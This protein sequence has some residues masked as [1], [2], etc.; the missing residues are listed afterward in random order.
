MPTLAK[1][2]DCLKWPRGTGSSNPLLPRRE[3]S[4]VCDP[5]LTFGWQGNLFNAG[6][7]GPSQAAN[8]IIA[9]VTIPDDCFYIIDATGNVVDMGGGVIT[10][11]RRLALEILDPSGNTAYS[12]VFAFVISIQ[13]TVGTTATPPAEI[14][15]LRMHL[16]SGA[17]VRWRLVDA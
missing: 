1:L 7:V 15:N 2:L 10:L 13:T 4:P 9:T 5:E 8:T 3:L 11:S 16:P 14:Y 12:L 17:I 6:L